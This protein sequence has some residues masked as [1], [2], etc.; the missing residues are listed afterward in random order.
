M[1]ARLFEIRDRG[2][3]IPMLAVQCDAADEN[4]RY[5]LAHAGFR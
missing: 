1:I 4:E 5:L 2:T 3:F